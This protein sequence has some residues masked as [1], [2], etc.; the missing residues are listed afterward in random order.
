MI[1]FLF[2]SLDETISGWRSDPSLA[3]KP[4][5]VPRNRPKGEPTPIVPPRSRNLSRSPKTIRK[6]TIY[7][8]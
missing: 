7:E 8:T 3:S 4:K 6:K 2:I 1:I 5:P